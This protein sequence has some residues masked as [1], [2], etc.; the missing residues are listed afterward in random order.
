MPSGAAAR[1][2][3]ESGREDTG[4]A[5]DLGP[6]AAARDA[7]VTPLRVI[8]GWPRM[9][10]FRRMLGLFA[11]FYITAA[12]S[13]VPVR[14]PG[15]RLAAAARGHR[16][17]AVRHGRLH[18]VPAA[19]AARRH[20]DATRHAPARPALADAAPARL[21]GRDPRL[22]AFL[23]AGEGGHPRTARL[24]RHPRGCSWAGA[25]SASRAGD[26]RA[27]PSQR[28]GARRASRARCAA[29]IRMPPAPVRQSTASPSSH[30]PSSAASTGS[31]TEH[32]RDE[33]RV[34]VPERPVVAAVADELRDRP[35]CLRVPTRCG[36]S[37]PA[38]AYLGR[39]RP[40]ARARLQRRRR[41]CRDR[42]R[43]GSDAWAAR[44][45]RK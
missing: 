44:E 20:L 3:R 43:N 9:Q 8:G 5:R 22:R 14:R 28:C 7:R 18:G 23:V 40:R 19:G 39:R 33:Q 15:L 4:H 10:P 35:P 1:P 2:R 41:R 31:P 25:C 26:R 17:A 42:P 32:H 38:A 6:A 21:C 30:Q 27:G 34:E 29:R 45:S 16:E 12:F 37:N 13:L 36:R 11:F 24:C